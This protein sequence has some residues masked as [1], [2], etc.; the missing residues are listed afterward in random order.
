M[1]FIYLFKIFS[2]TINPG[3]TIGQK[4]QK[5]TN[6]QNSPEVLACVRF[7]IEGLFCVIGELTQNRKFPIRT[8]LLLAKIFR[9]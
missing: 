8:A 9:N 1:Q 4:L 2:L 3:N 7:K 5:I 6:H